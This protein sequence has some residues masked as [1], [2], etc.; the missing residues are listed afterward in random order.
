MLVQDP[1]GLIRSGADRS[2]DE[3][4]TGGHQLGHFAVEMLLEEQVAPG[5]NAEQAI[6][7]IDD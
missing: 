2:G 3:L 4:L 6:A 5:Q 1:T 7:A